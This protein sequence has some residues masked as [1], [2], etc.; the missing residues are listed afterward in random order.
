MHAAL[1]AAPEA[2]ATTLLLVLT[3]ALA[4]VALGGIAVWVRRARRNGRL[5]RTQAAASGISAAGVLAIAIMIA[6]SFATP[7]I[8]SATQPDPSAPSDVLS[9]F[10]LPTR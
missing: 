5:D 8:A 7:S 3:V 2:S 9:G 6:A 10:Q 1:M 4:A